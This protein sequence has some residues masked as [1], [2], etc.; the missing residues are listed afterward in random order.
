MS[1]IPWRPTCSP[2]RSRAT[3]GRRPLWRHRRRSAPSPRLPSGIAASSGWACR[4]SGTS[5]KARRDP[6][7][8]AS[9]NAVRFTARTPCSWFRN[10][11]QR[12]RASPFGKA[13]TGPLHRPHRTGRRRTPRACDDDAGPAA[14]LPRT[15]PVRALAN[16]ARLPPLGM[17]PSAD[18]AACSWPAGGSGRPRN[19]AV[20]RSAVAALIFP[21]ETTGV[22]AA[23][24]APFRRPAT[25]RHGAQPM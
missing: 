6:F 7:V 15:D 21:S 18:H 3:P 8:S 14:R 4:W 24:S 13:E 22:A 17:A 2:Q 5:S 23:T 20:I 25:R 11:V 19:V 1:R 16:A 10:T 12:A 9:G